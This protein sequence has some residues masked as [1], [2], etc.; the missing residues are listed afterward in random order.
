MV[1]ALLAEV[2]TTIDK[3]KQVNAGFTISGLAGLGGLGVLGFR[4]KGSGFRVVNGFRR[5][6]GFRVW[7]LGVLRVA[8][9]P[10]KRAPQE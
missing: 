4:F 5:S 2:R 7:G 8:Q 10:F 9:G 3:N 6:R 1:G